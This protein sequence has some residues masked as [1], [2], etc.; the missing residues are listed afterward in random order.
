MIP[1]KIKQ[2]FCNHK[3]HEIGKDYF[4]GCIA[5]YYFRCEKCGKVISNTYK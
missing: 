5:R 3:W 4:A 2:F 1:K